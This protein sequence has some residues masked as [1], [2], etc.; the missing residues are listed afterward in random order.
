MLAAACGGGT[1][2][3]AGAAADDVRAAARQLEAAHPDLFHHVAESAF[4]D[5]VEALA[6]R[7]G[8]L[9][10]DELLVELMRLTALAGPRDGHTGIFPLDEGHRRPLHLLPLR[11]YRFPEG[12][13]VVGEVG[14]R[15][16]V[17]AK[18][19]SLGG[20]P[21]ARVAARVAPLVP[22][23]NAWSR[24]AR[25]AQWLVVAEVLRG[26]GLEPRVEVE[27][28]G[29]RRELRP[30][31]VAA[32]SWRAAFG[33]LFHPMVPQGLPARPRPAYL[34]RREEPSW[35]ASL[36]AGRVAYGALN[37]M[38][39]DV[40]G[41]A[42]ALG[43]L[44]APAG[45]ERVVLDLRHNPGGDNFTYVSLLEL[46]RSPR[47]DRPGRLVVLVGRT[48][49]SAAAN[50]VAELERTTGARFVGEPPGGSPNLYGDPTAA[51]LPELGWN[52]NVATVHWVKSHE[53]DDR[54]ALQPDERVLLTAAD[55]FAG[56]DPVLE[57]VLGRR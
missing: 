26:L 10:D 14:R 53:R 34:A 57:H 37:V 22:A 35:T 7:A 9:D 32:S 39:G 46:L 2:E 11:L 31:P 12:W 45:V 18:V 30:A 16:L 48:T 17:G 42:R 13:F 54:V 47:V 5:R 23:D 40:D 1:D 15:G 4:R 52:V 3:G 29:V 27:Q 24:R 56:R 25:T 6:R 19:L 36:A 49:F 28:H 43:A 44:A 8:E 50:L 41:F 33:D 38:L 20:E 51:R 21:V 55:Y